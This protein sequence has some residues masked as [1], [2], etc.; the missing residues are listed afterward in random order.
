M[1]PSIIAETL[2]NDTTLATLLGTGTRIFEL[3]SVDQRP[4]QDGYFIII[5][6]QETHVQ[7]GIH[8]GP[9]VMQIWVH[10][11]IEESR[12]YNTINTIFNRI[13]ALLLAIDQGV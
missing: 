9:R 6:M 13:D 8:L 2:A 7:F 5:D 4:V 1:M 12:T 3:Q 10:T 11:P